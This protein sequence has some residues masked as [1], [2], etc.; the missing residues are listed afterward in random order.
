MKKWLLHIVLIVT[1]VSSAAGQAIAPDG[2]TDWSRSHLITANG[3]EAWAVTYDA[4]NVYDLKH[5]DF[6]GWIDLGPISGLPAHGMNPDG[7]FTVADVIWHEGKV[8]IA[9]KYTID[10]GGTAMNYVVAWDGNTWETY[11]DTL[12]QT[13]ADIS[14]FLVYQGDLVLVG[15]FGTSGVTSNLLRLNTDNTWYEFGDLLTHDDASDFI[16]DAVVYNGIIYASGGFTN[17]KLFGQRILASYRDTA[18]KIEGPIPF[19]TMAGQFATYKTGMVLFGEPTTSSYD[20]FKKLTGSSTWENISNGLQEVE[21]VHLNEIVQSG[22]YLWAA[23]RF[24]DLSTSE[25]FSI[26]YYD[27]SAWNQAETGEIAD[28]LVPLNLAGHPYVFGNFTYHNTTN[29][30]RIYPGMALLSGNVFEDIN[31]DCDR[32]AGERSLSRAY[33][34]LTPGGHVIDLN[35]DGSYVLPVYKGDYTLRVISPPYWKSV[36]NEELLVSVQKNETVSGLNFGLEPI[37]GKVDLAGHLTDFNGWVLKSGKQDKIRLCVT[38]YGTADA[39]NVQVTLNLDERISGIQFK[40]VPDQF[41]G[42]KAVWNVDKIPAESQ[43][44]FELTAT[45][46]GMEAGD[47]NFNYEIKVLSGSDENNADNTGSTSFDL[48]DEDLNPISKSSANGTSI[49][50]SETHLYYKIRIQNVGTTDINRIV[51]LDTFDKNLYWD[52]M[53]INYSF[54]QAPKYD[55]KYIEVGNN[56][57]WVRTWTFENV[58]L[59]DSATDDLESVGFLDIKFKL[60]PGLHPKGTMLCNRAVVW[61]DNH[62]PVN[63]NKVCGVFGTDGIDDPQTNTLIIRPNPAGNEITLTNPA[64]ETVVFNIYSTDGRLVKQFRFAPFET[65]RIPLDDLKAGVYIIVAEGVG[66]ARFIKTNN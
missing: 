4:D 23:G 9:G 11:T 43:L 15:M 61:A 5:W 14:K 33:I 29:F 60:A 7:D 40:P 66:T 21:V 50:M 56:Y 49:S 51:I 57:Q 27:G 55:K 26:M 3:N 53:W 39:E 18:W 62:E 1:A 22:D 12:V 6:G 32:N 59:V 46:P 41:D 28:D 20:Y 2:I 8:F 54:E 16:N 25:Y 58:A 36:C 17:P 34:E 37:P 31:G 64:G 65:G 35:S 48:T 63:T 45:V 30:G 52:W 42:K 19:Q 10:P 38:N 24:R 44:C 13:S 47:L